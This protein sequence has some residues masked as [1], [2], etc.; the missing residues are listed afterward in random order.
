[1]YDTRPRRYQV[2]PPVVKNLIIIN[3]L[4]VVIQ[5]VLWSSFH[6][7][8]ADYLGLHYFRSELFRPWQIVTHLFMHGD[9]R[10]LQM[11]FLHIGSNMFALWMFGSILENT[12]GPKRF[13]IFYF[14]CGLGAALCH[15]AVLS[16][17]YEPV[18]RGFQ[19][20]M[21]NPTLAQFELFIRH[22][23]PRGVDGRILDRLQSLYND[24]SNAPGDNSFP[25]FAGQ[26]LHEYIYGAKDAA[27]MHVDGFL[28]EATVGA[29]GAVFGVLFA[30]GYL[31][32]NLELMLLFPP[33]PIKAKWFVIGY[34]LL[35]LY[36]GIRNTAGDNVAH[37]AHLG[38]MLFAFL[39]LKLWRY[40]YGG[41]NF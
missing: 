3:V 7:Q 32:P 5:Q 35:E 16:L 20:F 26:F 30:F 31:F 19:D 29:S 8:L 11:T 6:I 28:D 9:P 2:L 34:A 17:Q 12:W 23:P 33:I 25:K 24:W 37:F 27:G 13:L 15:L 39:L 1:M 36:S 21:S 14:I 18:V 38:G 22:H 40:R 10:S 4:L 41:R